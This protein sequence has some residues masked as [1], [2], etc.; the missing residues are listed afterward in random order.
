MIGNDIIDLDLAAQES[1]WQRK[2]F[3][4]KLFTSQEQ[5][6]IFRH[7]VPELM[8]WVL[9][10][11]KESAYKIYNRLT[12]HRA[13]VPLYFECMELDARTNI[14][15]GKVMYEDLM[16][17]TKT[18]VTK[19]LIRTIAVLEEKDLKKVK[20]LDR[21][22]RIKRTR[23]IPSFFDKLASEFRPISISHHGRFIDV[24][25]IGY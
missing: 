22:V 5:E 17:Y 18:L 19:E 1:N 16:F 12:A 23:G 6:M 15:Y 8:V 2:G 7:E 20:V 14:V 11:K 3:L 4:D 9:W 13:Y 25:T 24:V 10:S 21:D